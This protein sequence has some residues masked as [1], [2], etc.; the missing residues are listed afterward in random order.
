M[1]E[2]EVS[3]NLPPKIVGAVEGANR[4]IS[5]S[6]NPDKSSYTLT[7]MKTFKSSD[8][9]DTADGRIYRDEETFTS[10]DIVEAST[11]LTKQQPDGISDPNQ[12]KTLA[13]LGILLMGAQNPNKG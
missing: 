4:I 5:F 3:P 6:P 8:P 13:R 2:T 10:Q 1:S 12:L 9:S 7:A 11:W